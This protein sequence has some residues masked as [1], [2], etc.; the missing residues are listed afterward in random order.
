VNVSI[1]KRNHSL[2]ND[3]PKPAFGDDVWERI[4]DLARLA[5]TP[6]NTQPF[7]IRPRNDREADLLL[8]SARLLPEEDHGNLYVLSAF[9]IFAVALERAALHL[10]R[11]L[12]VTP[13]QQLDPGSLSL[14]S[15]LLFLGQACITGECASEPQDIILESRRTSRLPYRDVA[16]QPEAIEAL[17]RTVAAG[18]HRLITHSTPEVVTPLIR[19]NA[20]AIID[21]LQLDME[22]EEIRQWHRIGP[23]PQFGDGLW[24]TPMNQA[25]WE[26]RSAF[27]FPWLFRWPGFHQYAVHRYLKTQKGSRHIGLICGP[28]RK[29]PELIAGGRMLM[30]FWLCMAE[31]RVY[32]Q[33]FGSMLTNASYAEKIARQ[34]GVNDCWLIFRFGYS[35][36]PPRAPRVRSILL[37]E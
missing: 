15:G 22:R 35:D 33:P 25:G 1:L 12:I 21:N 18:G 23:T 11:T 6:H 5:P 31:H 2:P 36:V 37:H 24:P 8:E 27:A 10:G 29:W 7:R 34:F 28:F 16:L 30:E 19:M 4:A 17:T 26:L 3:E 13:V 32:M 20:E 14:R 9:G